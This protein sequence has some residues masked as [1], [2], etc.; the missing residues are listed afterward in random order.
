M[1]MRSELRKCPVCHEWYMRDPNS[2][3]YVCPDCVKKGIYCKG[4]IFWRVLR[5]I[6]GKQKKK[7]YSNL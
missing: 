4:S 7:K 2:P 5:A 3:F 1:S 6:V